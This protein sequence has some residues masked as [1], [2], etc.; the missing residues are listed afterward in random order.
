MAVQMQLDAT[1]F[2]ADAI[3]FPPELVSGVSSMLSFIGAIKA[4]TVDVVREGL[5]IGAFMDASSALGAPEIAGCFFEL[6][7]CLGWRLFILSLEDVADD[8]QSGELYAGAWCLGAGWWT[9]G[10]SL[11]ENTGLS[12]SLFKLLG[13]E[14]L[15]HPSPTR[16]TSVA[17]SVRDPPVMG[18]FPGL[19]AL[20][21][22]VFLL[23]L[24]VVGWVASRFVM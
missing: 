14:G 18:F 3:P 1:L 24:G 9:V 2:A 4:R 20:F 22:E 23:L 19:G 6:V 11:L 7:C 15:V 12:E 8:L 16:V 17:A 13:C 5:F 21:D 10:V